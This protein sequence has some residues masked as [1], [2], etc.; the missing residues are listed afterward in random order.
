[1]FNIALMFNSLFTVQIIEQDYDHLYNI[2]L[3]DGKNTRMS[4]RLNE[5]PSFNE[6]DRIF[7]SIKANCEQVHQLLEGNGKVGSP[8]RAEDDWINTADAFLC[9]PF[10]IN[11]QKVKN[12]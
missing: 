10:E 4:Y 9:N 6:G 8:W 7:M 5:K 3:I 12:D 11:G 2:L 1:M